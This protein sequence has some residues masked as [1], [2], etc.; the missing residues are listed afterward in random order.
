MAVQSN[1]IYE[2]TMKY[3][4]LILLIGAAV[5][6]SWTAPGYAQKVVTPRA[7]SPG[8]WRVIGTVE[9][10]FSADHDTLVVRGFDDF[11]RIKFKVTNAGLN[12]QRLVVVY[13]NGEPERIDVRANIPRG[14]ES[15]QIDLRGAGKRRIRSID[16]WY[17]T[18][19]ILNGKARVT[20]VGMK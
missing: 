3:L 18:K 4:R 20:V 5:A 15:R 1:A 8:S 11:R 7:G 2:R 10:N 6:L 12:L 14:G 19:G 16:F 17:D 13:E 9:A